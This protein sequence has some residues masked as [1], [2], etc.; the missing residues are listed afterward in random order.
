MLRDQSLAVEFK[1]LN[2]FRDYKKNSFKRRMI[3]YFSKDDSKMNRYKNIEIKDNFN[4]TF[5]TEN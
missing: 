5:V 4:R 2:T 3:S 1:H